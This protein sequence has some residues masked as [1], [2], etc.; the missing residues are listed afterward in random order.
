MSLLNAITGVKDAV[1]G[2]TSSVT[3]LFSN[4]STGVAG[5]FK[6]IG[7]GPGASVKDAIVAMADKNPLSDEQIQQVTD[8]LNNGDTAAAGNII[9]ANSSLP[10]GDID[11]VNGQLRD[12][13]AG[14]NVSKAPE[15]GGVALEPTYEVGEIKPD[16][17]FKEIGTV[18][19]LEAEIASIKRPVTEVIIHWTESYTNAHL[20]AANIDERQKILGASGIQY[21]YVIQRNGTLQRGISVEKQTDHSKHAA[22][23]IAIVLV[24]G[25]N[26]DTQVPEFENDTGLRSFNRVQFNT[27]D[28]FLRVFYNRYPGGQVLGH[29]DVDVEHDDPG[30]DVIEYCYTKFGRITKYDNPFEQE[31]FTPE[32]IN[33]FPPF[34]KE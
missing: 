16:T 4:I 10:R 29:N 23:T 15:N 25:Y 13:V 2:F 26:V 30:F 21:H 24:G 19:E 12:T 31:P 32:E 22:R 9:E 8:Y 6:S 7:I 27:L 17:T 34:D 33:S 1:S 18:E 3:D 20:T 28:E 5:I 11:Q 14:K